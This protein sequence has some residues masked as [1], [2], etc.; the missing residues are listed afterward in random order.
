MIEYIKAWWNVYVV[1]IVKPPQGEEKPIEELLAGYDDEEWEEDEWH[2][3][4][5]GGN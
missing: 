4:S 2:S 5:T 3:N 1:G